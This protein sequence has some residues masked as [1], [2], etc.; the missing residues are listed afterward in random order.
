[1]DASVSMPGGL[2]LWGPGEEHPAIT[3][4]LGTSGEGTGSAGNGLPST[5]L[6]D[7]D[8]ST[9]AIFPP[10]TLGG[11]AEFT[12][13]LTEENPETPSDDTPEGEVVPGDD[14]GEPATDPVSD[15]GEQ[16]SPPL[17]LL[18]ESLQTFFELLCNVRFESAA[19]YR[20]W[21]SLHNIDV[22]DGLSREEIMRANPEASEQFINYL[23]WGGDKNRIDYK[24]LVNE[25]DEDGVSF[26]DIKAFFD[27]VLT[28]LV[29]GTKDAGDVFRVYLHAKQFR[30]VPRHAHSTFHD[31]TK[32]DA[33]LWRQQDGQTRMHARTFI[34]KYV[35]EELREVAKEVLENLLGH[36]ISDSTLL[37]DELMEKFYLTMFLVGKHPEVIDKSK[38]DLPDFDGYDILAW[39]TK[40]RV[41]GGAPAQGENPAQQTQGARPEELTEGMKCVYRTGSNGEF[42]F[43][44]DQNSDGK[45][46]P[47]IL[48]NPRWAES[49]PHFMAVLN[50]TDDQAKGF[51]SDAF[52][53]LIQAHQ[54]LFNQAKVQGEASKPEAIAQLLA[55]AALLDNPN[56]NEYCSLE[57][58][59]KIRAFVA[60][61]LADLGERERARE[62]A[63]LIP[64][65]AV[66]G[67]QQV[68]NGQGGTQNVDITGEQ[69][70]LQ[71]QDVAS[72]EAQLEDATGEERAKLLVA[73]GTKL[74][75]EAQFGLDMHGIDDNNADDPVKAKFRSAAG[76][77]VEA[78]Q[79]YH[80][81]ALAA[82]ASGDMTKAQEYKGKMESA[83]EIVKACAL[84]VNRSAGS[85][86]TN[87][88]KKK[89]LKFAKELL[90]MVPPDL[91]GAVGLDNA[92]INAVGQGI[93]S[94]GADG[95]TNY[96]PVG[97]HGNGN[98]NGNPMVTSAV[99]AAL[100]HHGITDPAGRAAVR[101]AAQQA[102]GQSGATQATI[103]QAALEAAAAWKASHAGGG[104]TGGGTTGGGTTGGTTTPTL[105]GGAA[106]AVRPTTT[107]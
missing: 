77:V 34:D 5:D 100:T 11:V 58:Q 33:T 30:L 68:P 86:S 54:E 72:L 41:S 9:T 32:S 48:P 35:R 43:G 106:A 24:G 46:D 56:I 80:Q 53:Y 107:P 8:L 6:G 70:R 71:L 81:L 22:T 83:Y 20:S 14:G 19:E 27:E 103:N 65:E 62:I 50:L 16:A 85:L 94:Q 12:P 39:L 49:I 76:Y 26:E 90:E 89:R 73:L 10:L 61:N 97:G 66:I 88:Q 91:R 15:S 51:W 79:I 84:T 44:E 45:P 4:P 52:S 13:P 42:V 55:L 87:S 98:G 74:Y 7:A 63:A 60:S 47:A 36:A 18:D 1:M 69:F 31:K 82:E 78:M 25:A 64:D 102:A 28:P 101:T 57:Q 105:P 38:G 29:S 40:D 23:S 37:G 96:Q 92:F 21:L 95:Q 104:T 99:N 2:S 75:Q 59:Y 67:Q 93:I 17:F 3:P